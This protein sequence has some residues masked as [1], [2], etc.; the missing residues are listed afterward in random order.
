MV[1]LTDQRRTAIEK[2]VCPSQF[3]RGVDMAHH[4]GPCG[5]APGLARGPRGPS[6]NAGRKL[7]CGFCRKEW[8]DPGELA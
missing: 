8:V 2:I 1:R 3:P 4:R 5:E 6:E 7:Y